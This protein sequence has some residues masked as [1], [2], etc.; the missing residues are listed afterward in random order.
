MSGEFPGELRYTKDHEWTK[1]SGSEVTV[2]DSPRGVADRAR[3]A[4]FID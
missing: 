3:A 1:G 4:V 2:G